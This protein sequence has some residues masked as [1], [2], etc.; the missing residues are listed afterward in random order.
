MNYP[1]QGGAHE[2]FEPACIRLTRRFKAEKM[3]A[4]IGFYIH[5][6]ILGE[7]P[8]EENQQVQA[9][10]NEEMPYTYNRGTDLELKLE[11]DTDFY[12]HAWYGPKK[13]SS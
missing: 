11:L 8:P 2:V 9:Y 10:I 13:K 5:D 6:G 4:R 3:K 12:Q 7:C 1:V